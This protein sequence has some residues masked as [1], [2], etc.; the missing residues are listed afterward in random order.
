MYVENSQIN[1]CGIYCV[2]CP[3]KELEVTNDQIY[4]GGRRVS[5][6][7]IHCRLQD[8][9]KFL[10]KRIH[11]VDSKHGIF[12]ADLLKGDDFNAEMSD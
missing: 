4:A 1:D 7:D 8:H 12:G 6:L 11:E 2:D 3:R 5:C 9:C 10:I